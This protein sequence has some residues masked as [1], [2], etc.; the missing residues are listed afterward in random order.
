[1]K[2]DAYDLV[3]GSWDELKWRHHGT[4]ML[5]AY[6]TIDMRVHVW[7]RSLLVPGMTNSGAKHNHRF[8]LRSEILVGSLTHD[9]PSLV[10]HD[11]GDHQVVQI[12]GA[13]NT[14]ADLKMCERVH[15]QVT[16]SK[17]FETGDIY[18][19]PK[20]AFHWARQTHSNAPVTVTLVHLG[21]KE[22]D[23]YAS[24]VCP[25][26]TTPVHAF[27]HR[28]EPGEYLSILGDA[29]EGLEIQRKFNRHVR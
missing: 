20:W 6:I 12:V 2:N 4:G 13:S 25:H 11:D 28:V 16:E 15:I 29:R 26:G 18:E 24:L 7:S 1:M 23:R 17:Q 9:R 14:D 22:R 19:V 10:A 5:Q 8:N 3:V 27:D 21:E